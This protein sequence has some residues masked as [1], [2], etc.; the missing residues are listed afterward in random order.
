RHDAGDLR[1]P[2]DHHRDTAPLTLWSISRTRWSIGAGTT[3]VA[4][5]FEFRT[6]LCRQ[7]RVNRQFPALLV[8]LQTK[9]LGQQCLQHFALFINTR[10]SLSLSVD[11]VAVRVHPRWTAGDL[12]VVDV[13]GKAHEHSQICIS[14]TEPSSRL[15]LNPDSD[16]TGSV[17]SVRLDR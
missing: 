12:S 1:C 5:L 2:T 10:I 4:S 11:V 17:R 14:Y 3:R 15:R 9:A 6:A 16:S 13:V 7:Q 8:E